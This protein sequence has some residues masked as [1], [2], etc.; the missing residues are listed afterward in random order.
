MRRQRSRL[1]LEIKDI[2]VQQVQEIDE[3]D[4]QREGWAFE[5]L[6]LNQSYDPV[7][8]HTARQWY[9][10]EWDRLNAKRGYPWEENPWVWAISFKRIPMEMPHV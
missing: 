3:A 10:S 1:L 6:N 4:A 9:R 7:T 8:M 5:G 2:R